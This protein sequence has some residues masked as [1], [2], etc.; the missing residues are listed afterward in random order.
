MAVPQ[1][2]HNEEEKKEDRIPLHGLYLV[3]QKGKVYELNDVQRSRSREEY[4]RDDY[5]DYMMDDEEPSHYEK[6]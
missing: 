3:R 6:E 1:K 2:K 4:I 5:S